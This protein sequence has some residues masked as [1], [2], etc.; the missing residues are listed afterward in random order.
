MTPLLGA[1]LKKTG[2]Y[3]APDDSPFLQHHT[4][5]QGR[6][7]SYTTYAA[8]VMANTLL[9]V[10]GLCLMNATLRRVMT[11]HTLYEDGVVWGLPLLHVLAW[12]TVYHGFGGLTEGGTFA[13]VAGCLYAYVSQRMGLMMVAMMV[14][15]FQRELIPIMMMVYLMGRHVTGGRVSWGHDG[16]CGLGFMGV[17]GVRW[18]WPDP[19][20]NEA[21]LMLSGLNMSINKAWFLQG[22]MANNIVILALI[23]WAII[24][25]PAWRFGIPFLM[26]WGVLFMMAL[27]VGN[28]LGR[29]LTM[30][31]PFLILDMARYMVH[32]QSKGQRLLPTRQP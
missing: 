5:Y 11:P 3:Y 6:H 10:A 20:L 31:T 22:I 30:G 26:V 19:T 27:G 17:M 8:W 25:G 29:I 21:G 14:G 2:L 23:G 12:S 4:H 13:V 7:Y 28:N 24:R 32:A 1:V 18:M 16:V 9:I 15:V